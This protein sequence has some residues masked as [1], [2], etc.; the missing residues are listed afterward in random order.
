MRNILYYKIA[1]ALFFSFFLLPLWAQQETRNG[2][3]QQNLALKFDHESWDF[4]SIKE[5]GGD[6]KHVFT[7]KNHGT[8]PVVILDVTTGCGCTTPTY[9]R[10]PVLPQQSG[11]IEVKFD[12]VG[13]PGKFVKGVVVYTSAQEK[14]LQ[15]SISGDVIPRPKTMEEIYPFDMGQSVRLSANFHAFAYVNHGKSVQQKIE[16]I[17]NS[18]KDLSFELKNKQR[19]GY[20]SHNAPKVMKAG[21]R[22]EFTIGYTLPAK[23]NVYGS[24]NDVYSV[25]VQGVESRALFSSHAI[26]VD[27][28]D[29]QE[30]DISVPCGEFSKKFIKFGDVKSGERVQDSSIEIENVGDKPLIIRAVEMQSKSA[31]CSLK[32]GDRIEKGAK[33]KVTFEFDSAGCDYGIWVD[34]VK[35]I[36]NDPS[37]PMQTLRLTAIVVDK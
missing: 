32:V 5:D 13:R 25:V 24:L 26:A 31:K 18:G 7:F 20:F 33:R 29:A 21:E 4:G 9:S 37:R 14:P 27:N 30:D 35:I 19:S 15:L 23:S 16:W 3:A 34:R 36:T 17:N 11:E 2:G 28:F 6:V 10:K 12:P 1:L 22:G 8:K